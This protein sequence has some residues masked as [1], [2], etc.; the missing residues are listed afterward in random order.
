MRYL[1]LTLLSCLIFLSAYIGFAYNRLDNL[2]TENVYLCSYIDKKIRLT[3][4]KP[5]PKLVV[6]AGSNAY[7]GIS[8][9][10]LEQELAIPTFNFGIHAGFG[11]GF[12]LYLARQVLTSGDTVLL[13]L[14]YSMYGSNP[15]TDLLASV[16]FGCGKGF[17]QTT[18]LR[19][20]IT[21]LLSQPLTRLLNSL[22]I[23]KQLINPVFGSHGDATYNLEN[24]VTEAMRTRIAQEINGIKFVASNIEFSGVKAIEEFL[25]WCQQ[26][27]I[28]V[29]AT[30]PNVAYHPRY[31]EHQS[32]L[33]NNIQKIRSFYKQHDVEILGEPYDSVFDASYFYDTSH[34]LH[35]GGVKIRTEKLLP[36][37]RQALN[38]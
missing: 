27:N 26:N 31:K 28:R 18:S 4:A 2:T 30:W 20:K 5:T 7:V 13:P 29:L 36:L 24:Q 22:F 33:L 6:V 17:V 23:R 37:L 25:H 12:L 19:E 16:V 34:H 10:M 14:E 21:I 32:Y 35:Q 1:I 11:P 15:P 3:N 8:A 38:H 9:K